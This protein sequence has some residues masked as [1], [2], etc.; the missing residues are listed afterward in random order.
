ME[1]LLLASFVISTAGSI[2]GA[3]EQTAALEEQ[4]HLA[5]LN[6]NAGRIAAIED[7]RELADTHRFTRGTMAAMLS[8]SEAGPGEHF[9]AIA[10]RDADL[11]GEDLSNSAIGLLGASVKAEA[12]RDRIDRT[13]SAIWTTT[14]LNVAANAMSTAVAYNYYGAG[15]PKKTTTGGGVPGVD[16]FGRSG[17]GR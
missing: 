1:W 4:K 7:A 13:Q 10:K 3:R 9:F 2:Y 14:W 8:T 11:L 16:D 6:E 15:T 5:D 17:V 12:E